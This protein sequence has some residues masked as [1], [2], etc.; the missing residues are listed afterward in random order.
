MIFVVTN[1]QDGWD[2]V[3][4]VY[5]ASSEEVLKQYLAQECGQE[6]WTDDMS[7]ESIIT[8]CKITSIKDLGE[9]RQEKIDEIL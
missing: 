1:P 6:E 8:S 7:E 9:R 5:E 3:R 4:G 2:C